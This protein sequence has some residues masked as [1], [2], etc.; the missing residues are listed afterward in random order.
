MIYVNEIRSLNKASDVPKEIETP[1]T[2]EKLETKEET[3]EEVKKPI[4]RPVGRPQK[5]K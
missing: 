5:K 4:G 3:A 2:D 1:V